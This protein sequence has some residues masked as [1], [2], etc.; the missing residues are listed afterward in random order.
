MFERVGEAPSDRRRQHL[1]ESAKR[2]KYLF[3]RA[4]RGRRFVD[5]S[6]T[7]GVPDARNSALDRHPS[8]QIHFRN[9][10]MRSRSTPGDPNAFLIH[11]NALPLDACRPKCISGM[12]KYALARRL[13][14]Q[15]LN[16]TSDTF[17]F[18]LARRL[19]TQMQFGIA[20]DTPNL[21][22]RR[23]KRVSGM[24]KCALARRPSIQTRFRY[25]QT[26]SRSTPVDPNA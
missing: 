14:I 2:K 17:K 10:E 15:K 12:L 25:A 8:T 20:K 6:N 4:K 11:S 16:L 21:G 5:E 19:S 13:S 23:S 22:A 26:R 3:C 1:P 18:A 9:I 7:N 24:S